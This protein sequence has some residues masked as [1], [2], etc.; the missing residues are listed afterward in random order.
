MGLPAT[1]RVETLAHCTR[2]PAGQ[3]S[4]LEK[5][6]ALREGAVHWYISTA[7]PEERLLMGSRCNPPGGAWDCTRHPAERGATERYLQGPP[8]ERSGQ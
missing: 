4:E 6:P 3:D 7:S 5:W 1:A 2:R 8:G